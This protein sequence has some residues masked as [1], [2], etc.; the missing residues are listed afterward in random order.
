MVVTNPHCCGKYPVVGDVVYEHLRVL[1]PE[2]VVGLH[3]DKAKPLPYRQ[4]LASEA[5][6]LRNTVNL[7]HKAARVECKGL[8]AFLELVKFLHHRDRDDDIVVLKMPQC[9][10]VVQDDIG[11]Q[12]EYFRFAHNVIVL[13]FQSSPSALRIRDSNI[14]CIPDFSEHFT[15]TPWTSAEGW[16]KGK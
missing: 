10:I 15:S 6:A 16:P 2:R 9:T 5:S 1:L 4:A 12:N 13:Y 11:V 8:I 3:L 14:V 7:T